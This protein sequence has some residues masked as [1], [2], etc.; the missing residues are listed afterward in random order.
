MRLL[1]GTK[2]RIPLEELMQRI[3][4]GISAMAVTALNRPKDK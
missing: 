1:R 3:I 2:L 4:L